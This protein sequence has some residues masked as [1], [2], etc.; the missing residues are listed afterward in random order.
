MAKRIVIR[1]AAAGDRITVHTRSIARWASVRMPDIAVT[2]QPRPAAGTTVSVV[3]GPLVP[4]P[5]PHTVI[6]VGPTGRAAPRARRRRDHPDRAGHGRGIGRQGGPS[7]VEVELFRAE[8]RY[9]SSE[10]MTLMSRSRFADE[11]R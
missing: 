4:S 6:S 1:T 9:V 11:R 10:P 2:D 7:T 3:D 8:N 5:R